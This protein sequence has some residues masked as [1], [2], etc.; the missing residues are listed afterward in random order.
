MKLRAPKNLK[1]LILS[2]AFVALKS[3]LAFAADLAPIQM[4]EDSK[5]SIF[6]TAQMLGLAQHVRDGVKDNDRVYLFLQQARLGVQGHIGDYKFYSQLA[7]GGENMTPGTANPAFN[8]L[9]IIHH[10]SDSLFKPF[11]ANNIAKIYKMNRAIINHRLFKK[12]KFFDVL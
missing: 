9:D 6:G 8:L 3:T 2:L 10:Y 5:A 12:S 7:L 1:I 11:R 4:P